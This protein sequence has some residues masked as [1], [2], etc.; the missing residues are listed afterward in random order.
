MLAWTHQALASEGEVLRG[1]FFSDAAGGDGEA[2]LLAAVVE[3]LGEPLAARLRSAVAALGGDVARVT[4]AP[5]YSR[6]SLAHR[7]SASSVDIR[8][9]RVVAL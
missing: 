2:A 4:R 6:V 8:R 1:L 7:S 9:A 5:T 3:G